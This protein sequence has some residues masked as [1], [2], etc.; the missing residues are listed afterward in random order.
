[1]L[2]AGVFFYWCLRFHSN[3][4]IF[5]GSYQFVVGFSR[6]GKTCSDFDEEIDIGHVDLLWPSW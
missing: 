4:L 6:C 3:S 2:Q 1:M 5:A